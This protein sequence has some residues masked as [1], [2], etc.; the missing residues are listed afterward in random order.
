MKIDGKSATM[1]SRNI[2]FHV[3]ET[4]AL[5][6]VPLNVSRIYS[7]TRIYNHNNDIKMLQ[8]FILQTQFALT[9]FGVVKVLHQ[10]SHRQMWVQ[11]QLP[12]LHVHSNVPLFDGPNSLLSIARMKFWYG[13]KPFLHVNAITEPSTT[14]SPAFLRK[15]LASALNG[16]AQS[17]LKTGII[18][19]KGYNFT[20][21][22]EKKKKYI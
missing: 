18:E 1:L 10:P 6:N 17:S 7:K 22:F 16:S 9:N 20:H 2:K 12:F 14:L 21:P 15:Y 4:K 8:Y 11:S 3:T 13:M 19:E 5:K